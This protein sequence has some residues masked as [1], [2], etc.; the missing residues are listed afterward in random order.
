MV[1]QAR[2]G[3]LLNTA[4]ARAR[5]PDGKPPK[6]F[7]DILH[8][9]GELRRRTGGTHVGWLIGAPLVQLPVF[10]T[11]MLAV[12]RLADTPDIGLESGGALWLV[13]L[14]QQAI[15][16]D[17]IAVPMGTLG[18][19]LPALT[20]A[21]LFA[22]IN[23]SFGNVARPTGTAAGPYPIIVSVGTC[24]SLRYHVR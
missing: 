19:V 9:A 1:K 14:T 2:A 4:M 23:R 20:T 10:V 21:A 12:R 3:A 18:L 16:Y 7:T 8:A 13:D 22:N 5:G 15:S 17:P 6:S 11:S 24:A